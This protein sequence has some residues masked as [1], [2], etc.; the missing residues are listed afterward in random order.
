MPTMKQGL[1]VKE[2]TILGYIVKYRAERG[3]SP[4]LREIGKNHGIRSTSLITY[5]LN[6]LEKAGKLKRDPNTA[7]SLIPVEESAT[8]V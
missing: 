6:N 7:R 3:Y 4:S 8:N 5:Y 1:T 2:L